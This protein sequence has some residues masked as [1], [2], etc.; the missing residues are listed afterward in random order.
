MRTASVQDR[1]ALELMKT[2]GADIVQRWASVLDSYKKGEC[3][4]QKKAIDTTAK[5]YWKSYFGEYG[6]EWVRDVKRRFRADF[7][8]A[9]LKMQG[10]DDT[11]TDYYKNYY[12]EYGDELTKEVDRAVTKNPKVEPEGRKTAAPLGASAPTMPLPPDGKGNTPK[13]RDIFAGVKLLMDESLPG[14]TNRVGL[15]ASPTGGKGYVVLIQSGNAQKMAFRERQDEALHMF[16]VA[17]KQ[18]ILG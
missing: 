3:R 6:E 1:T 9:K 11:A 2:Y 5:D 10:I 13:H 15:A 18:H 12:G 14:G 16:G 7:V 8:A 17:V 4:L